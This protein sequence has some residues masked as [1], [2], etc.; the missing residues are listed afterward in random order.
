MGRSIQDSWQ[1]RKPPQTEGRRGGEPLRDNTWPLVS[2]H[3]LKMEPGVAFHH[4]P[5]IVHTL[6]PRVI[7][8]LSV[9]TMPP[10]MSELIF[11]DSAV[12]SELQHARRAG[13]RGCGSRRE[14]ARRAT[15]PDSHFP[16]LA[17]V[18]AQTPRLCYLLVA[19]VA[20]GCR[21]SS[22]GL[23]TSSGRFQRH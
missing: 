10:V 6:V 23:S 13:A 20:L 12:T 21:G 4:D 7:P 3:S 2:A 14:L 9:N 22:A 17:S 15:A 8:A 1:K 16:S 5:H 19:I 18:P 11:V